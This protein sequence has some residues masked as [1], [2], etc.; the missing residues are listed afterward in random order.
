[1]E[2]C[3]AELE[4]AA[5]TKTPSN[6]VIP[7]LGCCVVS[8]K[9]DV[10]K[11]LRSAESTV[12]MGLWGKTLYGFQRYSGENYQHL[13]NFEI[14]ALHLQYKR[15]WTLDGVFNVDEGQARF[16]PSWLFQCKAHRWGIILREFWPF[17]TTLTGSELVPGIRPKSSNWCSSCGCPE[18][19]FIQTP[20]VVS[21]Q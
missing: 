12:V 1:M 21:A 10:L 14:L 9:Y 7:L 17:L 20:E 15:I 11:L 3:V 8:C 19:P 13:G 4:A 5:G 6:D 2:L 18:R 16:F